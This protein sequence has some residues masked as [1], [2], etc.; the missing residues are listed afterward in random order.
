MIKQSEPSLAYFVTSL[1]SLVGPW[2]SNSLGTSIPF[3][4]HNSTSLVFSSFKWSIKSALLVKM[5]SSDLFSSSSRVGVNETILSNSDRMFSRRFCSDAI[6]WAWRLVCPNDFKWS[7]T[8]SLE[9]RSCLW[10]RFFCGRD[11]VKSIKSI[12]ST[13]SILNCL[14]SPRRLR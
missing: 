13:V 12:K 10:L 7:G 2:Y 6:W 11:L 14:E 3:I 4:L 1:P 8:L 9:V 5:L